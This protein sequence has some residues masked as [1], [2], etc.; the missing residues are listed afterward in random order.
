[1]RWTW[2]SDFSLSH[3]QAILL[4]SSMSSNSLPP[5]QVP[6]YVF[7]RRLDSSLSFRDVLAGMRRA[8]SCNG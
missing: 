2:R 8:C 3:Q 4:K 5:K 1:M 7:K 6:F